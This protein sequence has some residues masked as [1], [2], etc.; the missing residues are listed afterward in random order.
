MRLPAQCDDFF[1]RIHTR[2]IPSIY[3]SMLNIIHLIQSKSIMDDY[4]E[5]EARVQEA[6]SYKN[7]HPTSSL[8]FLSQQFHVL[9]DRIRQRLKDQNSRSTRSP[10]N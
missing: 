7:A 6:I 10:T 4:F 2:S 3:A 5:A 1:A 8:Q 9:K